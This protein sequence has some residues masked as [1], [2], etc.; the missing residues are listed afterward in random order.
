MVISRNR[1]TP[2]LIIRQLS[3]AEV[4]ISQGMTT[5]DA[6]LEMGVVETHFHS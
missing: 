4:L 2:E 5:P 1:Y 6:V 3:E